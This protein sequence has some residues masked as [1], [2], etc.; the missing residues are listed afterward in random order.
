MP[1]QSA[2]CCSE[3]KP[4]WSSF[5]MLIF[6]STKIQS[7]VEASHDSLGVSSFWE[8]KHLTRR[9]SWSW[10]CFIGAKPYS[11]CYAISEEGLKSRVVVD[12]WLMISVV[13]DD[14]KF[15][16]VTNV[17]HGVDNLVLLSTR[18]PFCFFIFEVWGHWDCCFVFVIF[19]HWV[20]PCLWRR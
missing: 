2:R 14:E 15:D 17:W 6:W 16:N 5:A 12:A 10:L 7:M 19:R 11:H 8:N 13:A 3:L 20:V 18:A 9:P 1:S 4:M